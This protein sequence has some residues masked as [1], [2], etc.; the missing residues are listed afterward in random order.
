[1]TSIRET[2]IERDAEALTRLIREVSPVAVINATSLAHR[3]RTVPA[4]ANARSWVAEENG[5]VVGRADAFLSLFAPGSGDAVVGVAV[6][7]SHRRRGIGGELFE[8]ALTHTQE[9]G[10]KR[11]FAHFHANDAGIAF[12]ERHGFV[13]VRAETESVLDPRAVA[14]RADADA[15]SMTQVDPR[16]AYVIDMEATHDMPA[17]EEFEGMTYEEWAQHV[18]DHPLFSPAGSFVVFDGTEAAALSLLLVDHDTG[19]GTSMFTGTRRAFRG[20]GLALAAKLAS[21]E[22]AAANGVTTMHTYNDETNAPM[23]AVNRRLGYVPCGRQVEMLREGTA[24]SRAR[25]APA[26]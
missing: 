2:D 8:R 12:A 26:T 3:M 16:L 20:R 19:R 23:L 11:L 18:L 25:Q 6:T 22:W 4:S 9:L 24:S 14:E 10:A 17:T 21:I 13:E 1:M 5:A 15:R 7:A